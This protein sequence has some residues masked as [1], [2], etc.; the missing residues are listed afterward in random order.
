[1]S[2]TRF[3]HSRDQPKGLARNGIAGAL[4]NYL[5]IAKFFEAFLAILYSKT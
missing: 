4:C 1:L 3:Q 5:H 2:L